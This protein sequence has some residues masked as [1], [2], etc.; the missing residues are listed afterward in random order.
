MRFARSKCVQ[1][2]PSF[3]SHPC[4]KDVGDE[5]MATGVL[6]KEGGKV[7][8]PSEWIQLLPSES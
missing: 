7:E 6:G 4:E 5:E 8:K 3:E 1:I 2:L